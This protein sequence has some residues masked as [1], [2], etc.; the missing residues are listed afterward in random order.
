MTR[1][2]SLRQAAS[3]WY[4]GLPQSPSSTSGVV[5][6]D[7]VS[8][9]LALSAQVGDVVVRRSRRHGDALDDLEVKTFKAFK[10]G[11]V[12]GHEPQSTHAELDEDLSA[13]AVLARVNGQAEHQVGVDRVVA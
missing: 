3:R 4:R 13:D 6:R 5:L 2:H 10:L 11:G 9:S 7:G 8:H 12:V 1:N